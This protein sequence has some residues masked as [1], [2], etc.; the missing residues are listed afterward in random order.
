MW[1]QRLVRLAL[2]QQ[3]RA[4]YGIKVKGSR[5]QC[6]RRRHETTATETVVSSEE[7]DLGFCFCF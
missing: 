1:D 4:A 7:V 5:A 6:D 3:L 2:L